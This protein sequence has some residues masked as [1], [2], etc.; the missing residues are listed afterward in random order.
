MSIATIAILSSHNR[1]ISLFRESRVN[2][3]SLLTVNRLPKWILVTV[4]AGVS[5][6]DKEGEG[7]L[8]NL[9]EN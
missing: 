3:S 8:N 5:S 1:S 2:K 6:F 4:E 9:V 7:T